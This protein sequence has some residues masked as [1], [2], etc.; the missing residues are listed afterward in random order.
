MLYFTSDWHFGEDRIGVNGKA[1]VF[2]RPFSSVKQQNEQIAHQLLNGN[3]KNGDT[4][5][6]LGDVVY[7]IN[8]DSRKWMSAI[9]E[10]FNRSKLILIEGNYDVEKL[11]FLGEYFDDIHKDYRLDYFEFG[12]VYMNHYPTKTLAGLSEAKLGITGHVHSLWK[13]QK[14][15]INVGVDAW[16]FRPVSEEEIR[17]CHHAIEKIYDN[18]VFPYKC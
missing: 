8:E 7:E 15:L 2:Y 5:Y 11:D 16:H 1:N 3:F 6:H 17:F 14:H 13:V 10:K 12:S 9:R 4:L 18:D